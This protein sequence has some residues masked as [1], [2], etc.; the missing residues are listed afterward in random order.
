MFL[1]YSLRSNSKPVSAAL[2]IAVFV[3][4]AYI[5]KFLD[6]IFHSKTV[7]VVVWLAY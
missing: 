7:L 2:V 5:Y 4:L 6:D 3:A 1:V